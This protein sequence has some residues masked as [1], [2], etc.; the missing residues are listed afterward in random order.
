MRR[1]ARPTRHGSLGLACL[2]R[3]AG[4]DATGVPR[5]VRRASTAG[6]AP[7][8]CGVASPAPPQAREPLEGHLRSLTLVGVGWVEQCAA[9]RGP[10]IATRRQSGSGEDNRGQISQ[11]P[12]RK[13]MPP[14]YFPWFWMPIPSLRNRPGIRSRSSGRFPWVAGA[15]PDFS[16][17]C[18]GVRHR[19][20]RGTLRSAPLCPGHPEIEVRKLFPACS[21]RRFGDRLDR[22][23]QAVLGV[24]QP[25]LHGDDLAEP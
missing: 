13:S 2:W 19:P 17:A 18:P 3:R 22:V 9:S 7:P 23:A 11:L 10:P 1:I 21:S 25:V 4:G 16:P 24:A 12:P 6:R 8:V 14:P 15:K 5:P 20:S